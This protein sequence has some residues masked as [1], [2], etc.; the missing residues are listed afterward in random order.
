MLGWAPR[1]SAPWESVCNLRAI[2]G[3]TA[4]CSRSAR[5]RLLRMLGGEP[6]RLGQRGLG[7]S[8]HGS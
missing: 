1:Y 8:A 6:D 2:V 5:I 3:C 4:D 7:A